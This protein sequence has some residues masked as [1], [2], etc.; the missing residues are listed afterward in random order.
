M[1]LF[2]A[3]PS[4]EFKR[5]CQDCGYSWYVTAKE[6]EMRAPAAL[7]VPGLMHSVNARLALGYGNKRTV[8]A[9][10]HLARLESRRSGLEAQRSRVAEINTCREC[11]SVMFTERQTSPL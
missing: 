1:R 4:V 11:G 6:R 8:A 10:Q 5:K 2:K 7:Q 9:R 3:K